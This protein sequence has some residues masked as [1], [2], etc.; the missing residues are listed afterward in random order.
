MSAP[1]DLRQLLERLTVRGE[2]HRIDAAVDPRLEIAAII[3]RICKEPGGG[4]A[5]CFE[6]PTGFAVPVL[7]NLFGSAGRL[8][9][10]LGVPALDE[11][12]AKL[13]AALAGAGPG[14]GA[15]RMERC[16]AAPAWQP[17]LAA[18]GPCREVQG[19]ADLLKAL[20]ALHSWPG[21]GGRY[22]TLP[23]VFTR[24]PEGG[25]A[26]CGIYRLQLFDD[27]TLGLHLGPHADARRHLAAWQERGEAMP[28][29]VALGGP[30]ALLLAAGL[31]LPATVAET[32]FA[33]W[34]QG[35]PLDLVPAFDPGLAVPSLAEYVIEGVVHPGELRLEGPF[36]NH[37]GQ[38]V[39]AAP[40]PLLRVAQVS[41]RR[42]P[43]Y[44]CTVVGPPPMEDCWLAKVGERLLLPLL[45]LDCPEVVDWNLPIETIFHG[46]ALVAA[47]VPAKG[48]RAL[49][50]RLRRHPLLARARLLV[51]FDQGVDVQQPATCYWQALN[52]V[53][54]E[55]GIW[56]RDGLLN[57]DASD[58]RTAPVVGAEPGTAARIAERWREFGFS[59]PD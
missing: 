46:A 53:D 24:H 49:L 57:I 40:A 26:N 47:R 37:T 48:G 41:R 29:A 3:D 50:E 7:A 14:S 30:P 6:N 56:S 4:P 42:Q 36:G 21:D 28:V 45:Q 9:L 43:L 31:P 44:P 19:G 55:E 22:L 35:R 1:G 33:G 16:F 2:L 32:S 34:L 13:G 11:L 5:L 25:A 10:A 23:L 54:P 59:T 27:D 39:P 17:R 18:T 51:L 15:Q 52:R 12:G 38:Y 20:P 8:T 58:S